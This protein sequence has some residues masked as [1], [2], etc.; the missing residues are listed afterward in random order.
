VY[1]FSEILGLD[2][3]DDDARFRIPAVDAYFTEPRYQAFF[4]TVD[5]RMAGL[6][7]V[8]GASRLTGDDGVWDMAEF[9]VLRKYR[10]RGVGAH[11]ACALF[12]R[13][14]GRWE[15]RQRPENVAATAFWRRTVARYTGGRFED[16]VWD[17]ARW[18]GPVQRFESPGGAVTSGSVPPAG[19]PGR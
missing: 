10:R 4:V 12:D 2:V 17:D 13:L 16:A 7:L 18:R 1:D 6:A 3:D 14:A 15:V 5:S 19:A 11:A 8:R 9:F